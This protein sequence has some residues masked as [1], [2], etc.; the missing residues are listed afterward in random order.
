MSISARRALFLSA[1][2]G[3]WAVVIVARLVQVQLIRHDDYV[4]RAAKQQERTL[5]LTPVRGSIRDAH[6]RILAESIR[7]ESIYADPQAVRDWKETVRILSSVRGLEIDSADL[8]KRLRGR[9]EFAWVARQVPDEISARVHALNLPGIYFL[10]EHERAYPKGSL[11]ANVLGYVNVDGAGLA[12]IEYSFESLVRGKPGKVTLLRDARQRMYM[13]GG[14][15]NNAPVDGQHVILTIDE[16][17]QFMTERA[18]SKAAEKYHAASGSAIVM[19]PNDGS[20][21]AMASYPTFDPNEFHRAGPTAWRNRPVQDMYE[22]GSTFKIVTAA[23]ALEDGLVTPSQIIDCGPG[24]IEIGNARIREHGGNHYGYMSFE[25]VITH[26]S[27]VGTIRTALA[28][29]PVRFEHF[30]RSFGFGEQTGITLPGETP[31]LLRPRRQWSKLSN[32]VLAIGQEIGVSPLQLVRAFSIVANGGMTIQPRIVARVVDDH[33]RTIYEPPQPER[34]RVISERTA[35]ILNQILKSVVSRGTGMP[36]ALDEYVVAGKTGTAQKVVAG[37]YS[38]TRTVASFGGYVPA[39][40][41]R[42]AI[43]VVIDDPHGGQYGGTIAAPAFREI[44]EGALRYLDVQPSLP[45]RELELPDTKLAA[46]S[47]RFSPAA[48]PLAASPSLAGVPDLRGLDGRAAV[49]L[50]TTAG[51]EVK[52]SGTGRVISQTPLP[53]QLDGKRTIDLVMSPFPESGK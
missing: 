22:P 47:Q 18:L 50:A 38:A 1:F 28:L 30:M 49:S 42:L 25:D 39:D 8:A 14:D 35:T 29:G 15:G 9:G 41:P 53:G 12:G 23:G 34:R 44:A 20:I 13:V 31:G 36:A 26:S 5:S 2:L 24:Y 3:A 21:L 52:A 4:L 10:E 27:N 46:F 45:A 19:D 7:V 51:F 48:T 33:G 37:H 40:R 16:V 11:A 43:L 17:V 6:G 32:A